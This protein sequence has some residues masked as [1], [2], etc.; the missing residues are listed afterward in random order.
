MPTFTRISTSL[1]TLARNRGSSATVGKGRAMV[2]CRLPSRLNSSNSLKSLVPGCK[3]RRVL[4]SITPL[5]W[6][7][8]SSS[9]K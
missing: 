1:G 8:V 9:S 4:L 3:A 7:Q 6:H 2:C 5:R